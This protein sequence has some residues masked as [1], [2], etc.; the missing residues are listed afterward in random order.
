M[1]LMVPYVPLENASAELIADDTFA[2][3]RFALTDAV[4]APRET[5][6]DPVFNTTFQYV[7]FLNAA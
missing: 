3:A 5:K 4:F 2:E 1:E 7:A 6:V